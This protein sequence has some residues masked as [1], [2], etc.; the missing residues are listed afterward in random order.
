MFGG[1]AGPGTIEPSARRQPPY[2]ELTC[3]PDR[4]ILGAMDGVG[5]GAAKAGPSEA[6]RTIEPFS[7]LT[8]Q[9]D[10][11]ILRAMDGAGSGAAKIGAVRAR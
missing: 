10:R 8:C 7:E 9:P 2:S 1:R 6:L 4:A 3:Q 11:A 5:S